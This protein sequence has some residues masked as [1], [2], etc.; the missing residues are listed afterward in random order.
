MLRLLGYTDRLSAAPGDTVRF[1]VSSE[2]PRYEVNLVRLIHGDTNPA[3]P[4]FKQVLVP[5]SIDGERDGA[6]HDI[7]S[8]S[9]AE[10]PAS[11]LEATGGFTFTAFV[12]PTL[13]GHGEQVIVSRGDPFGAGGLALGLDAHGAL[14]LVI[15][16]RRPGDTRDSPH[17]WSTGAPMR[18][19]EWYFAAVSIGPQGVTLW[20]QAV[21]RWPDDP[22]NV[23]TSVDLDVV[24]APHGG[25]FW[26]GAARATDGRS[27]YHLDG[28][29][30]RPRM[31]SRPLSGEEVLR[32]SIEPDSLE[33]FGPALLAAW[34][35]SADIATD[36][37]TD[38]SPNG[39]HGRVVNMPARGVTGYNFSGRETSFRLAPRE[40]GAIHFHHDD[41]EDAGWPVAFE[42][43]I[44]ADL[45]SGIYAAWL[46]AGD[47]EDYLPFTVRPPRGTA[48][49]R[50]AVLMSTVTYV[51]YENFTDIGRDAWRDE[52]WTG[53]PIAQ[54]LA[55]PTI[56]RDVYRY[57]E[58]NSLY[59]L[60]DVHDDGSGVCYGSMLR[61][62]LNMRPKFRYRTMDCPARFPADLYLVDWLDHKGIEVDYITDH[63]LHAEGADL[64][65]PYQVVMSSGHHEYWTSPML[66]ALETYL[67]EGGRFMYI[68][69]NSLFGVTSVDPAKP[70]RVEVRRWGA[71]WPFEMPPGERFHSTTGEQGGTW[72]NRGRAPNTIVG[73]GTAGAGFD[74]GSP[75]QRMPDSYDPRASW[76]FDGIDGDLIG[77]QPNLQVRW[78]A[79]GYEF[80][81]V[82]FEL[83]SP[84]STLTLASSVRFNAL[85]RTM[86]DEE[87]DFIPGRDGKHPTDPQVPGQPHRF[88]RSDLAYLEYPNGGA[89]FSA[90]AICWRGGLSA[91]GYE[92]TV[93]RVTENVLRRFT[94][95]GWRRG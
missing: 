43:T 44:P 31:F 49:S 25:P 42:L 95:P 40:Y 53:D 27:G 45:P 78:G 70:H 30:D 6:H 67:G 86:Q 55:D 47:D 76:I 12:Q 83:G 8:G 34:D 51:V 50:I 87:L 33:P 41:L 18:R 75:Y 59:G 24:P 82:E 91:Y 77:D 58:E 79:A 2:H 74:R 68:G 88:V 63:D 9:Y 21:R 62:I 35:F 56:F 93:S 29:L 4:G 22:S 13:P 92:N 60:Y 69:G 71:P 65:R 72:R 66:D 39:R 3:G 15:A 7:R 38:T 10:I 5:S 81:R 46:R 14:E 57:I 85:H 36:R 11:E 90:G 61:P 64:L 20:Q 28:R 17:R 19:W 73:I 1:M 37:V 23:T 54:P 32:I 16:G 26:L 52:H 84:G 80:D 48:R 94:D 89:V